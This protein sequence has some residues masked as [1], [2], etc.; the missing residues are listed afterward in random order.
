MKEEAVHIRI[1]FIS[2][3]QKHAGGRREVE[4]KL[5]PDAAVAVDSIIREFQIPWQ[6]NLER[7]V[8][9]FINRELL[10]VFIQNGKKL[11]AGD[12]IAF[13]PMSGGG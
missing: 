5:P 6:G 2:I 8:R 9:V 4:M 12:S 7:F 13:I 1:K 10:P 11:K 3:M